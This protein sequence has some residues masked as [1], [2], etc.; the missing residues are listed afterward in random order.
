[1]KDTGERQ[2]IIVP[3]PWASEAERERVAALRRVVQAF[4]RSDYG[5]GLPP[6]DASYW[7]HIAGD[8]LAEEFPDTGPLE[9]FA[10]M[11][12]DLAADFVALGQQIPNETRFVLLVSIA[13][14]L[15][16]I[17]ARGDIDPERAAR[18]ADLLEAAGMT[19]VPRQVRRRSR[20]G[21]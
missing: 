14:F 2:H 17:A 18:N 1:M 12:D 4:L 19:A 11:N 16:F 3:M 21:S 10:R 7:I 5:S 15:R 6:V 13:R 9:P 8:A 20:R